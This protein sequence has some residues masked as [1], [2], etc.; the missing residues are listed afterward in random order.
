MNEVVTGRVLREWVAACLAVI[1]GI[2]A[3]YSSAFRHD[4]VYDDHPFVLENAAVNTPTFRNVF[5]DTY[6][7]GEKET[8]LYRPVVTLTYLFDRVFAQDRLARA[9][10]AHTH[11]L[12]L[13]AAAC[14][15]LFGVLRSLARFPA[16]LAGCA[17]YAVHPV[18]TESV[19]WVSGRAEILAGLWTLLGV[20]VVLRRNR[21]AWIRAALIAAIYAAALATKESTIVLPALWLAV[22]LASGDA[23][24]RWSR[25]L[26]MI[27]PCALPAA[28]FL[29]TRYMVFGSF[30]PGIHAFA[31]APLLT[32]YQVV[33]MAFLRYAQLLVAPVNLTVH[34]PPVP[35]EMVRWQAI[36]GAA[37]FVVAVVLGIAGVMKRRMWGLAFFWFV[38][39][40]LPY[41][42][43]VAPIGTIMAERFLY[44][45]GMA[46]AILVAALLPGPTADNRRDVAIRL[47]CGVCT[48]V[49]VLLGAVTALQA[50][51]WRGEVSLWRA[52]V[53]AYPYDRVANLAFTHY[54]LRE[55]TPESNAEARRYWVTVRERFRWEQA[56]LFA[57]RVRWIEQTLIERSSR[58]AS[59]MKKEIGVVPAP[60][61]RAILRLLLS[62]AGPMMNLMGYGERDLQ[63]A[64]PATSDGS[65]VGSVG[66]VKLVPFDGRADGVRL[67]LHVDEAGAD[68]VKVRAFVTRR[69]G[70]ITP[71]GGYEW[72]D[73]VFVRT[74]GAWKLEAVPAGSIH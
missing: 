36:A 63:A 48:V 3:A 49:V 69:Q 52:A 62:E 23:E 64:L 11:N 56:G 74:E 20:A 53:V 24:K 71:K 12:A 7:P 70:G 4:F 2:F 29:V 15:L 45:P 39:A 54:L 18:L 43:I 6:P 9:V 8:G 61:L 50:R 26:L 66:A 46:V 30:S 34:W 32:K 44:V 19:A 10:V 16:A 31:G 40:L 72:C 21:C 68:V 51:V 22:F 14:L 25:G 67:R 55:D 60:A 13:H 57:D 1:V 58:S 33:F 37:V 28:A 65:V 27:L 38:V 41:S 5:L 35:M 42:N 17:I 47:A 73:M 59:V